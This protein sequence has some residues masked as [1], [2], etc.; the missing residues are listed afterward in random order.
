[1]SDIWISDTAMATNAY[2]KLAFAERTNKHRLECILA[3]ADKLLCA[4]FRAQW[5]QQHPTWNDGSGSLSQAGGNLSRDE[6]RLKSDGADAQAPFIQDM[7]ALSPEDFA[8][9]ADS[10]PDRTIKAYLFN[11]YTAV[12][13]K[14]ETGLTGPRL[15]DGR[16][17][18]RSVGARLAAQL[19]HRLKQI[20]D[21]AIQFPVI[22]NPLGQRR[23]KT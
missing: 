18:G 14:Y 17:F 8:H 11:K 7:G 1:M 10:M 16:F 5:N 13:S 19:R 3:Y 6:A 4:L 20:H 21:T 2:D 15:T 9:V 22:C 12:F 23:N